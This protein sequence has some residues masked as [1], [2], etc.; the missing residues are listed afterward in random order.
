[1]FAMREENFKTLKG[2]SYSFMKYWQHLVVFCFFFV[3]CFFVFFYY[4]FFLGGGGGEN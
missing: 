1:M 2:A 4:Y 3:Y